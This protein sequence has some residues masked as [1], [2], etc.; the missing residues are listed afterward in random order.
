MRVIAGTARRIILDTPR[1][2]KTR[3]T[4]D[5]TKETLFNVL[6][7][8]IPGCYFLD[9]FS[10]SGAI[11][12]E[13]L[14]RGAKK[15]VLVECDRNAIKCINDNVMRTKFENAQV[16]PR[17][18]RYALKQL[19]GNEIFDCIF[20]DPPFNLGLEKEVLIY[21]QNSTL[22]AQGGLIVIEASNETEFDYLEEIGYSLIREKQY[23][24][25]KHV[26]VE[27]GGA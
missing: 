2:C 7:P 8:I 26:F 16:M 15:C 25:N 14:S 11:G 27:R 4:S 12:I 3:P 9:L 5:R 18:V 20:M 23:K 21:L 17:D 10:G 19:E 13:A 24:T 6:Q 1:G 22:L